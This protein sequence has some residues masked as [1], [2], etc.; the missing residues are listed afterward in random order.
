MYKICVVTATRAEYGLLRP[1]L[2]KLRKSDEVV[3]Q[4]VVTG[5]HLNEKFGKTQKEIDK[6]GLYDYHKIEL[7]LDDDSKEA[8]ATTTGVT[9][10][11]FAKLFSQI[12]PEIVVVLGDRYEMLGVATAAHLMG[13]PIAHICGGD[14]TEGAV[15]DAVR[16]CITKLSLLHFAGC[17]ESAHRIIQLG[18]NPNRVFNVGELGVENCMN[19][20]LL[21]LNEL[22]D[23]IGFKGILGQYS[24]V[25]FHP[26]TMENNTAESQVKELI[27]AMDCFPQMSYIVTKAN[28]DTGGRIINDIWDEEAKNRSNWYVTYSLGVQKYLS[29]VNS[30]KLVIGNSSS[31]L[32][33]VPAL[34]VPTINIGDRQ[35]GRL[36]A[37][38]VICCEPTKE[39]IVYAMNMGLS[40]T[41]KKSVDSIV[42][43]YGDGKTSEKIYNE[44]IKYLKTNHKSNQKQFYDVYFTRESE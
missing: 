16:H 28:A 37:K 18:E 2:F 29:A 44:L 34:K 21:S 1:L 40:S 17:E 36:M 15:D 27:K 31:G 22:A 23:L 11:K 35:K 42:L 19:M 6:D 12:V 9:T 7:P 14:V 43:P 10:Q 38:S 39:G 4:L 24:I 25:T 33:E 20:Q 30:A 32:V 8:M 5:T 41:F 13:I 3:L 26:V